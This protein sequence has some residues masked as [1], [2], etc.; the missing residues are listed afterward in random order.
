[1]QD[2]MNMASDV[3]QTELRIF[4]QCC[5]YFMQF[6]TEKELQFDLSTGI[7]SHINVYQNWTVLILG[8]I[9]SKSF[10]LFVPI[11]LC[12]LFFFCYFNFSI[13]TVVTFN[14]L[15]NQTSYIPSPP[16]RHWTTTSHNECM[17][18]RGGTNPWVNIGPQ[19]HTQPQVGLLYTSSERSDGKKPK[20]AKKHN[21]QWWKL[22]KCMGDK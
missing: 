3:E 16:I 1:M 18:P 17:S 22:K 2:Q 10:F 6:L 11:T 5:S 8:D 19:T 13:G 7:I 4:L 9:V 12:L 21:H 14:T 20:L 15:K